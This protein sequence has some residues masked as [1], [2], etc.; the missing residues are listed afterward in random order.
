MQ[1]RVT[2]IYTLYLIELRL[3]IHTPVQTRTGFSND[4]SGE[5]NIGQFAIQHI[6]LTF[7]SSS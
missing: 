7:V 5:M 1:R 4:C 3:K 6:V 2:I